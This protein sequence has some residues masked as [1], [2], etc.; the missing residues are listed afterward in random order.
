M[1]PTPTPTIPAVQSFVAVNTTPQAATS[2]NN[3]SE[4]AAPQGQEEQL[5]T[6]EAPTPTVE[7]PS[8]TPS[9]TPSPTTVQ[10]TNVIISGNGAFCTNQVDSTCVTNSNSASLGNT[11]VGNTTTFSIASPTPTPNNGAFSSNGVSVESIS[12]TP[13]NTGGSTTVNTGDSTAE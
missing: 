7:Q 13:F 12:P 1:Q 5:S 9:P 3:D 6:D 2:A 4:S 8:I 10:T 11:T